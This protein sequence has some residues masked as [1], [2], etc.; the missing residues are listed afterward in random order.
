MIKKIITILTLI[1]F[2]S[3]LVSCDKQEEKLVKYYKSTKV[4]SGSINLEDDFV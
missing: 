1:A 3:S 4:A 2:S